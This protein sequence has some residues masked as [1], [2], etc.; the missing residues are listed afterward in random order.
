VL[1]IHAVLITQQ[2]F[3][4]N[5]RDEKRAQSTNWLSGK[6][7]SNEKDGDDGDKKEVG[8]HSS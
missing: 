4:K 5:W 1:R 7:G 3:A 6:N 2:Q 8:N